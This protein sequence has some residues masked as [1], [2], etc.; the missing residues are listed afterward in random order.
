MEMALNAGNTPKKT[1]WRPPALG[2]KNTRLRAKPRHA[3]G[4]TG[5]RTTDGRMGLK[6]DVN[7]SK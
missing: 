1:K 2:Q 4:F 7:I 3:A 5:E 6:I